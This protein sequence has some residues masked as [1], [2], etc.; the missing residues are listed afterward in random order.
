MEKV[1]WG[2]YRGKNRIQ[3]NI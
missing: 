3:S 1:C 2:S